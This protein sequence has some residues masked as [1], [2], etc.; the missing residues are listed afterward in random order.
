M[1][2]P[3]DRRAQ[4]TFEGAMIHLW[5]H[6]IGAVSGGIQSYTLA[7]VRALESLLGP[8]AIKISLKHERVR[9]PQLSGGI[10]IRSYG[11]VPKGLR[12]A[13]FAAGGI[14]WALQDRPRL[15]FSCHPNFA[16]VGAALGR[17]IRSQFWTAAHGIDAWE[18]CPRRVVAALASCD[19]ILAVSEFTRRKLIACHSLDPARISV[20]PNTFDARRFFPNTGSGDVR[21]ELGL[22]RENHLLLS[23]GRMAEPER[24]K[25]FDLVIRAMPQILKGAPGAYY[26]IAGAGP[27]LPRLRQIAGEC[28]VAER[29]KFAGFVPDERLP[30][31]YNACDAFVLPSKKEG[32]GIVFLEAL[33]C[34]SPVI[35]GT[36]DASGEALLGGELGILVDPDSIEEIAAASIS[37]LTRSHGRIELFDR[38]YLSRRVTEAF[39]PE[40][41]ANSLRHLLSTYTPLLAGGG[42]ASVRNR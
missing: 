11:S 6:D 15:I 25:G 10:A 14:A 35:A 39:G 23:V 12:T 13:A 29:V 31:Y 8:E 42:H 34:G 17:A 22:G 26:V 16:R 5:S 24:M 19:R 20:L 3:A 33:A 21:E 40:T 27:D 38:S 4:T 9:P 30:A 2:D 41:F 32:F 18:A 36:V 7:I 28:R 1:R 37:L